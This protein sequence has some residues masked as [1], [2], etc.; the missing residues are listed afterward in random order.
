MRQ[1]AALLCFI[2][3]AVYIVPT[4]NALRAEFAGE[5]YAPLWAVFLV[6]GSGLGWWI[7]CLILML[8]GKRV[9]Q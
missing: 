1:L 3:G 9:G 7:A 2:I 6:A 5:P 8:M 4:I